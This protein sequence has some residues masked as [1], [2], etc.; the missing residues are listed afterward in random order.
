MLRKLSIVLILFIGFIQCQ[1]VYG[2]STDSLKIV[3]QNDNLS[4]SIRFD[5]IHQ[6]T[7][8]VLF[9]DMGATLKY[10]SDHLNL[11]AEQSNPK[12]EAKAYNN[13][14]IA[15]AVRGQYDSAKSYYVLSLQIRK[16]IGDKAGE[17]STYN[18]LGILYKEQNA[19]PKALEYFL[20]SLEIHEL[21]KDSTYQSNSL[22]NIG[23]IYFEQ[24][25][26]S[27][28]EDY[29][30]R[31]LELV[32]GNDVSSNKANAL[33]NLGLIKKVKKHYQEAT[34]YFHRV[35]NIYKN[36]NERRSL[37]KAHHNLGSVFVAMHSDSISK[38]YALDSA[39]YHYLVALEYAESI[40]SQYEIATSHNGIGEVLNLRGKHNEALQHF[41]AAE[42]IAEKL[43]LESIY[44][45][46]LF[47]KYRSYKA[48][49]D[50]SQSLKYYEKHIEV[51]D[52]LNS[53]EDKKKLIQNQLKHDYEKER[54]AQKKE[55]EK[56]AA[57]KKKENEKEKQKQRLVIY[58]VSSGLLLILIFTVFL[59]NR[60]RLIKSQ[61]ELIEDQKVEVE[62]Q[63]D[64]SQQQ[65]VTLEYINKEL[66]DSINYAQKIQTA[67]LKSKDEIKSYTKEYFNIYKP[68]DI[69]SGDFYWAHVKEDYLYI[70]CVDCTGHGVPGAFMSL[71]G[72]SFLN[73]ITSNPKLLDTNEILD[74]LRDKIIS[75]LNQ[76]GTEGE[77]RDGM[78]LALIRLHRKDNQ[79]L[80]VQFS[81]ANNPLLLVRKGEEPASEGYGK[82]LR[83]NNVSLYEYKGDK[84]PIGYYL[85]MTP[86]TSTSIQLK[87]NDALYMTSDG[88]PDQFGG[89]KNK[90]FMIKNFKKLLCEINQQPLDQQVEVI[91][92]RF[93]EYMG[94]HDQIDDVCVIGVRV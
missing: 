66:T 87:P 49:G 5:A 50:N 65:K 55:Q 82:R 45:G 68:K 42:K 13:L 10:T 76:T 17:A 18:N 54:L 29:F 39:E 91:H 75:E 40:N 84:Q 64:I 78:D 8:G 34:N 62:K 14:G 89:P 4:D 30:L 86:F 9:S 15:Y 83:H 52:S 24:D 23:T 47:G 27:K 63:R 59:F 26:F 6:L 22:N 92:S 46:S 21:R 71:L 16:D 36:L 69:V 51:Q 74:S 35:K 1:K 3:F 81:G 85:K 67:I 53:I 12:Q 33:L 37:A 56:I 43:N 72:I 32:G 57:I 38:S 19:Y 11:A 28:A 2:Q 70:A 7:W 90:R 77:N 41:T 79:N 88:F 60:F 48:L 80:E 44:S 25:D 58:A 31:S 94:D 61:K 93:T 73:E 20:K